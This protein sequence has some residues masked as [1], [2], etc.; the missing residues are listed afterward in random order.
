MNYNKP[1]FC[2]SKSDDFW[3]LNYYLKGAL[4]IAALTLNVKSWCTVSAHWAWLSRFFQPPYLIFAATRSLSPESDMTDSGVKKNKKKT[5][6][7]ELL[8][9]EKNGHVL[10]HLLDVK[11]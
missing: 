8:I 9:M 1:H 11:S 7:T 10:L 6:V 4:S 5:D 3:S 2:S